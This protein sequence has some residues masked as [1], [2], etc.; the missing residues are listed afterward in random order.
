MNIAEMALTVGYIDFEDVRFAFKQ[1]VKVLLPGQSKQ[2][3]IVIDFFLA[4]AR[5]EKAEKAAE[6]AAERA[7]EKSRDSGTAEDGVLLTDL[8]NR[9]LITKGYAKEEQSLFE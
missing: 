2:I 4:Q 6:R 3:E 1:S 5:K 8:L 7:A 9:D